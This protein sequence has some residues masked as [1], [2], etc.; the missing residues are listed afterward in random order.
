VSLEVS[1]VIPTCRRPHLLHRCLVPLLSQALEPG[2]YEIIVVDDGRDPLTRTVVETLAHK[3]PGGPS[4]RYLQ[5]PPGKRG[6]AAARNCGWRAAQGR[7]IAFTDD[8]TIPFV[9]WLAEGLRAMV[10]GIAAAAGRVKVP[11]S[12]WP[13]DYERNVK[14]MES[15]EFV[16]ANCFVRRDMLERVGGFDER[17]TRAWREDSDL[18]FT[19]LE[20]GGA[21][22][23]AAQALVLHPVREARWGISLREQRNMVFDA[24]LYKKHPRLYRQR[25]RARPPVAYY[26][27]VLAL[28]ATVFFLLVGQAALALAAA[29]VWLLLTLKFCRRRLAGT[30]RTPRHVTEMIATSVAIPVAAVYWRLVGALRFRSP[31]P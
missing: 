11:I 7:I 21:V 12:T 9:N 22:V 2:S 28:L 1:V 23:S 17:F 18:H 25:I 27:T 10:P 15:A 16:T 14:R 30:A 5:P 8:D 13:T 19:L 26:G 3:H 31:F 24:L 6:P 4:L 20:H 29:G